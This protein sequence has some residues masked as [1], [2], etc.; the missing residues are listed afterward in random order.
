MRK[1]VVI[2][3]IYLNEDESQWVDEQVTLLTKIQDHPDQFSDEEIKNHFDYFYKTVCSW[4][5]KYPTQ[6]LS[7]FWAIGVN[8]D[9]F[10]PGKNPSFLGLYNELMDFVKEK[11]MDKPQQYIREKNGKWYEVEEDEEGNETI[12]EEVVF[13]PEK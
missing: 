10:L 2:M 4:Q 5:N 9:G 13:P 3:A 8:Y 7:N 6:H 1:G 11:R 12:I